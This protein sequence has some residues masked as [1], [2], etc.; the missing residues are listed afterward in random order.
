MVDFS[1]RLRRDGVRSLLAVALA[2][3]SSFALSAPA[4]AQAPDAAAPMAQAEREYNIPAQPL[5]TALLRFA[6]QSDLQILFGQQ[7]LEGFASAPVVGRFT[8]AQALSVLMSRSDLEARITPAGAVA[9]EAAARPQT[10][11]GRDDGGYGISD[12][13]SRS[14]ELVVTGTRIRGAA[15][16]GANV[17]TLDRTA[18]DQSGRS[19]LAD[20]LQTLPQNF[21]GS[22]GEGTQT[23]TT[24]A[25]RNIAFASSVDLRGLGADATLT[26]VN[27]RRLAPAGFGN[28]VDISSIPLA[29]VERVEILADGAS[30][31]Y[32]SDA[33]GGVV[34]IILR[35]DFDGAELTARYGDTWS[36]DAAEYGGAFVA[37]RS[38]RTGHLLAGVEV[39]EREALAAR[40]RDY[41]ADSDL[42]PFGGSN[43]STNQGN[44]GTITRIG[45]TAVTYA[46]P[47]GQNGETLSEADLLPGVVNYRNAQADDDLLPEQESTSLFVTFEQELSPSV[48]FY[49]EAIATEREALLRDT[50]LGTTLVVPE[51]NYY[52]QLNG[53][54]LGQGN[55][56]IAYS[57]AQD[58]GPTIT[59]TNTS[60]LSGVT[61]LRW[62]IADWLVDASAALGVHNDQQVFRNVYD[63][64]GMNAALASGDAATAFNPFS[65]GSNTPASVLQA[66]RLSQVTENDSDLVT[67]NLRAD[68]PLWRLPAGDVRAALGAERRWESFS[69]ERVNIYGSG[70]SAISPTFRTGDRTVDA[71][72]AEVLI[73]LAS[74]DFGVPLIY[75]ASLS[76]SVRNETS[77][78]FEATTPK[79]GL[80]WAFSPDLALRA[81]WGQS[82]KAPQFN[83]TLGDIT[84]TYAS[85][86]PF[87]DP[88]ADDGSTGVLFLGGANP[89]L[90]PEEADSWTAGLHFT[91][92]AN[93]GFRLSATYFDIDFANRISTPTDII[94]AILNPGAFSQY[95]IRDPSPEQIAYYQSLPVSI[96]GSLP[97]EGVELIFDARL[98]NL[99]ALRVRGVDLDVRQSFDLLG[100]EAS[101][102]LTASGLL[103]YERRANPLAPPVD[104]LN[105]LYN[106]V[107]WHGRFGL[108]W[109]DG[110]WSGSGVV[111]YT[112]SYRNTLTSP[113]ADVDAWTT[114][115][116]RLSRVWGD[117]DAPFEMALSVRNALDQDPPFANTPIG[118]GFDAANAS[119]IGRFVS[120]QLRRRW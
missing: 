99:A 45:A 101:L 41:A 74:P 52:R 55:L 10:G 32:G 70:A 28:F 84:A 49:A 38:W 85:A 8:P 22:Q 107:D 23:N 115:D 71:L 72:Y 37:G 95:L 54:F 15:P 87:I 100:G 11:G 33:V 79:I 56:T 105:T 81:S 75:E 50:Q 102:F 18:I 83:Q 93:P 48:S 120:L 66:L 119:P 44:P 90:A 82:F 46:I 7:E 68:G 103:Q 92:R 86:P 59:E 30:A 2:S 109:S 21:S 63:S 106:P 57:M 108:S 113:A 111:N 5:S 6:E 117:Q 26:L 80:T 13:A 67:Y 76:L 16:A 88:F 89:D 42:R 91:P 114:V 64:T 94:T 14:D 3:V 77:D 73:P 97:P 36:G 65:D 29:A 61:G 12:E 62:D 47:T 51:S 19:T 118:I 69:I 78:S 53:L 40:A 112:N 58:L 104:A 98:T 1:A 31:T 9:I 24:V 4:Q 39:R 110:A 35:S 96:V 25:G 60:A 20:V 17:I 43:F 116:L 27:G 34:N